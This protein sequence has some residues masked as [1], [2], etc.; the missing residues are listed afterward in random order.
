MFMR[1][2]RVPYVHEVLVPYGVILGQKVA[3][4][5][6]PTRFDTKITPH[7]RGGYGMF[8]R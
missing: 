5:W 8:M 4:V 2:G 1:L 3:I 7:G 6:D